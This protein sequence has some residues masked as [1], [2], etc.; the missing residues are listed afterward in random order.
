MHKIHQLAEALALKI[1][2]YNIPAFD[3]TTLGQWL[4]KMSDMLGEKAAFADHLGL[5]GFA[6]LTQAQL[7]YRWVR[8]MYMCQPNHRFLGKK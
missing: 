4:D 5:A 2:E 3:D 6:Y 1:K 7:T 8:K